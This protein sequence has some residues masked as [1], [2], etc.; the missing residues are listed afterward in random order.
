[1]SGD[2]ARREPPLE[3]LL[4]VEGPTDT[5]AAEW[6]ELPVIGRPS[7]GAGADLVVEFVRRLRPGRVVLTVDDDGANHVTRSKTVAL[8]SH[9]ALICP[10][11]RL[12]EPFGGAKDIREAIQAGVPASTFLDLIDDLEPIKPTVG[13]KGGAG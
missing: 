6:I 7:N 5:L 12:L 8:A 10:D 13:G 1:M 4:V 11:V 2:M 3:W 9:L